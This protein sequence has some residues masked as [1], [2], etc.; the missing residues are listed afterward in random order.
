MILYDYKELTI[1]KEAKF[2]I[3]DA[4]GCFGYEVLEIKELPNPR[5]IKIYLRRDNNIN[6][7]E[8]LDKN[9]DLV[10]NLI[11]ENYKNEK[12]K[13]D[14]AIISSLSIGI[15]GLLT[16]GGGFSMITK[17]GNQFI[18]MALGIII[19]IIGIIITIINEPI[20]KKI[21]EKSL[22]KYEPLIKD[23]QNKINE[24]LNESNEILIKS[25]E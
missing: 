16:F 20:Y 14:K 13:K 3:I 23:N 4:T 15:V 2:K 17:L 24:L 9:F 22:D 21:L 1:L 5:Y 10:I 7:K 19:G 12:R 11:I 25:V 18:Y 6:N 8:I